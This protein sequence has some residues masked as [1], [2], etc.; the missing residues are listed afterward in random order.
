M[1]HVVALGAVLDMPCT[2]SQ[3]GKLGFRAIWPPMILQSA[4]TQWHTPYLLVI[5]FGF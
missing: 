4:V 3:P 5:A 2:P 1:I